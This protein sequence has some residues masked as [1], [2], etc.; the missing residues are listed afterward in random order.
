MNIRVVQR[1]DVVYKSGCS[2]LFLRFSHERKNK[3]VSLGIS[4]LPE[5]WDNEAQFVRSDCPESKSLNLQ[6]ARQQEDYR[7][8]INKLEVLEKDVNFETLFGEK[9]KRINCTVSD[10]FN[11]Q[12]DRLKSAGKIAS[13][14]KYRFC[15][16]ALEKCCSVTLCI[17]QGERDALFAT[18]LGDL[19]IDGDAPHNGHQTVLFLTAVHVKQEPDFVDLGRMG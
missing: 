10:Y 16:S 1:N 19:P 15:L 12:I 7:K 6:I 14:T 4:I 9:C 17:P 8:R 13:A 3:L 18:E 2:P 11:Q 5:F